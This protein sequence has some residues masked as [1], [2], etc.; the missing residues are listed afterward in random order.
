MGTRNAIG[1][2]RLRILLAASESASTVGAE[3]PT[4]AAS[5]PC[6][7]RSA[8]SSLMRRSAPATD[9]MPRHHQLPVLTASQLRRPGPIRSG[10]PGAPHATILRA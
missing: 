10:R 2:S 4:R 1:L 5:A 9:W 8:T 3:E 7:A 6:F